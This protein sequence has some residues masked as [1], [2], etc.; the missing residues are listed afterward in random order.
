V[1]KEKQ[2]RN[3]MIKLKDL[4]KEDCGCGCGGCETNLNESVT[5]IDLP[6]GMEMGK[7][8]TGGG[9][10]FKPENLDKEQVNEFSMNPSAVKKMRDEFK[11]TGELPPHLK[12]FA[13][14]L[15]KFKVKHKVKN[16]VVPGLEWMSDIKEDE[17]EENDYL[18]KDY[19]KNESLYNVTQD[20]KDG[21]FDVKN[22]QVQ[23]SGYGVTNLKTL[24]DSLSRKFTD[25]AKK[26]K[27]GDVEN[28][29]YI[30]KKNGVLMGFV[31]A[32]V[33]AN[34]ELSSSKMKRKITMYKRKR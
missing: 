25:L 20:M 5:N 19:I 29:E 9:F 8:F 32:L 1:V 14:D 7:I 10:A 24:Q 15:K 27:K 26:A 34:K 16:I 4:I 18:G 2:S 21:K 33:D 23:I 13:K 17:Q 3:T 31:E 6:Q 28:I 11:K 30:L 22:P 12:K